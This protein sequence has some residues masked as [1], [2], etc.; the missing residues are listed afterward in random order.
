MAPAEGDRGPRDRF[1]PALPKKSRWQLIV[2]SIL[3]G[4]WLLFLAWMALDP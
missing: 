3:L 4:C 2:S 1:T